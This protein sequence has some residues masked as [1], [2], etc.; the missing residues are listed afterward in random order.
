MRARQIRRSETTTRN[1]HRFVVLMIVSVLS[2]GAVLGAEFRKERK[3]AGSDPVSSPAATLADEFVRHALKLEVLQ[4]E[5][6]WTKVESDRLRDSAVESELLKNLRHLQVNEQ[7]LA[8]KLLER[9]VDALS[10]GIEGIQHKGDERL[11]ELQANLTRIRTELIGGQQ[12]L[13]ELDARKKFVGQLASL[14]NVD[15]RWLWFWGV[16]A[17]GSLIG[18]AWYDRRHVLRKLTWVRRSRFW[19]VVAALVVFLFVPLLPTL[20]GFILGN[21]PFD[22]LMSMTVDEEGRHQHLDETA[23][24]VLKDQCDAADKLHQA[25]VEE[26]KRLAGNYAAQLQAAFGAECPAVVGWQETVVHAHG[27][28]I[29]ASAQL[30]LANLIEADAAKLN[31]MQTDLQDR[32]HEISSL[33]RVK[34]LTGA[35]IG[36]GLLC[37]TFA[38]GGILDW[39]A[40][41]RKQRIART[42]PRCLN[43]GCLTVETTTPAGVPISDPNLYE[44]RCTKVISE[45]PFQECGF[46]F[47]PQHCDRQKL[48]FPTLGVA[49]SGKT[50]WLAMTYRE[51]NHGRHPD[52]VHFE[53]VRS[54]GST[55][56]DRIIENIVG[57]RLS[58]SASLLDLPHP[59]VFDF[60]DNDWPVPASVMLNLFDFAGTV[61]QNMGV[62]D[63]TRQRQLRSDGY[64][65][66]LDPT[67]PSDTQAQA[68]IDFRDQVKLVK[69]LR[70]GQKLHAPIALCVTKID[71]LNLQP[72]ARGGDVIDCFYA[73]LKRIDPTGHSTSLATLAEKSAAVGNLRDSIW[74]NWEIE[75]QVRALFGNRVMYF[76]MTPVGMNELGEEDLSKRTISPYGIVQP[77]LWLLHMNGHPVLDP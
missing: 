70:P 42:C 62:S 69:G 39:L 51:L 56:F 40:R 35:G 18:L 72:F 71:L 53:R 48:S 27:A 59:V 29:N 50:L 46:T 2:V 19:T 57:S 30:A 5:T 65:F 58:P 45:S 26:Y 74:P 16:L 34:D 33:A 52:N 41:Q 25:A 9:H 61:T 12:H 28:S 67:Y 21:Q 47:P 63:P 64:L 60:R 1:C 43:E 54:R 23:L 38:G 24:Q 10:R 6:A 8:L 20:L 75:K 4:A 13:L 31:R 15:N 7:Q 14:V 66:F 76:P 55:D 44:V 36:L 11:G 68:L 17:V 3:E 73:D 22:K 49:S 32:G 77:L 37:A